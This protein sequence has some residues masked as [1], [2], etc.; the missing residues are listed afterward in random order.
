MRTTDTTAST[1]RRNWLTVGNL[2]RH[3]MLFKILPHLSANKLH[4]WMGELER[5][6]FLWQG[7]NHKSVVT[8][9][10]AKVTML[11]ITYRSQLKRWCWISTSIAS[12]FNVADFWNSIKPWG[13][14]LP[15]IWAKSCLGAVQLVCYY[16]YYSLAHLFL[17]GQLA[18]LGEAEGKLW[19]DPEETRAVQRSRF[20]LLLTSSFFILWF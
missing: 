16:Y 10:C 20:F 5:G 1:T 14:F 18:I 7:N 4:I 9:D 12:A 8:N 3:Y 15:W 19:E 13:F 17:V 11:Y 2:L 6:G